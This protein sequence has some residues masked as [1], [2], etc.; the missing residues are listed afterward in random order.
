MGEL[1]VIFD[2]TLEIAAIVDTDE[3]VGYGPAMIGQH[4]REM[5]EAFVQ[6]IPYDVS[7]VGSYELRDWFDTFAGSFQPPDTT[8]A[9]TATAGAVEPVGSAGVDTGQVAVA[10]AIGGPGEGQPP[11]PADTDQEAA[12]APQAPIDPA[13]TAQPQGAAQAAAPAAPYSGPCYI[14]N[15]TGQVPGSEPGVMVACNMCRG[16]GHL[17]PP[18]QQ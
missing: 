6:T 11:G 10:E 4:A 2:P 3:R 17:P 7:K 5:L 12:T 16:T 9:A 14:C 13:A 15:A 18:T 1:V 8:P